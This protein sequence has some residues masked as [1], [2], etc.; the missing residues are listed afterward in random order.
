M[1]DIRCKGFAAFLDGQFRLTV[2]ALLRGRCISTVILL[3]IS[4]F[5][6]AVDIEY[7]FE[8]VMGIVVII[9]PCGAGCA[10][11]AV[12]C[13]VKEFGEILICRAAIEL[14]VREFNK[15]NQEM[16]LAVGDTGF[17]DTARAG[18]IGGGAASCTLRAPYLMDICGHGMIVAILPLLDDIAGYIRCPVEE[19]IAMEADLDHRAV[20]LGVWNEAP[21]CGDC[22]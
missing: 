11:V 20:R 12:S 1:V 13:L 21:V 16:L 10:I 6:W 17:A 7:G 9:V 2:A 14:H 15:D 3:I 18:R 8:I 4:Q 5:Y 19:F 22:A